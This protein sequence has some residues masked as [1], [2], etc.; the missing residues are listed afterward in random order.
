MTRKDYILIAQT[1]KE[2]ISVSNGEGWGPDARVDPEQA[3][4]IGQTHV[5][6]ELAVALAQDNPTFDRAKFLKACGV[7]K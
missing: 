4:A 2:L 7:T 1:I 5:V 3:E 6:E